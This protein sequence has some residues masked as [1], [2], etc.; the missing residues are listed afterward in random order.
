M[1][2][3][4]EVLG[5]AL[6]D[7][8]RIER[9][10]G[11]GGMA[12]VYLATDLKHDREVALKVL[13]PELG[14]VLGTERFLAE[15]KI[16]AR[17]DH[18]HILTLIDSGAEG[19]L[20]YY[21]LP[22]VRGESLRDKLNQDKQLGLEE[23]LAITRQVASALDYAHRHGV[24]HRDIK[25][26]NILLQEGEAMLTD[27]GIA[28]AV[29][30]AGGNR[31]TETGL[32]LGTPMYMS[33]EQATGDR[34]LDARSDV[35]S[36]AA[37]LYEMLS[38]E[39][40]V[41]GPN[42]QAMI[43]KLMTERPT[44]LRVVRP[45]VPE[46]V[47][48][49]VARA[50]DKTPAD[51]F[52]SAGDF[53]RALVLPPTHRT[54]AMPSATAPGRRKPVAAIAAV[55]VVLL[56]AAGLYAWK[57][58]GGPNEKRI[59][60]KERV[61]VTS[62]GNT[63]IPALSGDGKQMAF[64]TMTCAGADCRWAIM[65]QDIGA[66]ATREVLAGAT[67]AYGMAWSDDRRYLI[68]AMTYKGRYGIYLV[69]IVGG[70]PRY[71][72]PTSAA[73]FAGG[74]SLYIGPMGDD[75]ATVIRVAGI[76]GSPRDSLIMPGEAASFGGVWEVPGTRRLV[77][78]QVENGRGRWSVVDRSGKVIDHVINSCTCGGAVSHDAIWMQRAGPSIAEA[79]VRVAL[80][81][82]T[83]RLGVDQDTVYNGV[84]TYL[85]VTNDGTRVM[86]DDGIST[87]SAVATD[88][89][90]LMKGVLPKPV[91]TASALVSARVSPDGA[92]LILQRTMPGSNGATETKLSM[93]PWGGG[94][95]IPL[96]FDGTYRS[97]RWVDSVT[98]LVG[99]KREVG[100]R[101]TRIDIRTGRATLIRDLDSTVQDYSMLE[102]GWVFIPATRDRIVLERNG[103][104]TE[105][106]KPKWFSQLIG[107]VPSPDGKQLAVHGWGVTQ[108]SLRFMVTPVD[109]GPMTTWATVFAE[110]GRSQ[111]LHD[112]SLLLYD[113]TGPQT[114][115]LL[116]VAG[117]G[118]VKRL[119]VVPH[120]AGEISV[121]S[122]LQRAAI[123]WQDWRSDA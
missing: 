62:T 22:L 92:R 118:Q 38:G 21:V 30:E 95:E 55:A 71:L 104:R 9:P 76:N 47:D 88:L 26:E 116:Q 123:R 37:V 108:D 15:I 72:T 10:L 59:T 60:L 119:G 3:I 40:P 32:S 36:L 80:D 51:R 65:V 43:A 87:F 12:T 41:T 97:D 96:E 6:A 23:A 57:G 89:P 75:S 13:R 11:A 101:T 7:R 69:S 39:P 113:Y 1:N 14:A 58:R 74:D 112:G 73:F 44:H 67:A 98:F 109:G 2:A 46:V 17:L 54:A 84:F 8:Y 56:A 4:P 94:P 111:W 122:D 16:T 85:S 29:K 5:S 78:F 19:G 83:G 25:P 86:V 20:L 33:P 50:L 48:T 103:K 82:E 91:L 107:V 70:E 66:T 110:R 42:A 102:D 93:M 77:V 61:Q 114:V 49:A 27:F 24:I 117:P 18:P 28:L 120:L 106:P 81:P 105:I 115:A 79:V 45:S 52:A 31:L 68:S 35:Y 100:F 34:Q 121:S 90:A 63:Q 99:S 64:Y 53:A